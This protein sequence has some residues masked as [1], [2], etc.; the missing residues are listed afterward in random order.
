MSMKRGMKRKRAM[1]TKSIMIQSIKN[2]RTT[3]MS[4]K[5]T[6]DIMRTMAN[7]MGNTTMDNITAIMDIRK[8]KNNN[9][10]YMCQFKLQSFQ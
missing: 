8:I 4:T 7:N 6:K 1:I 5:N 9:N 2:T 10:P 3:K